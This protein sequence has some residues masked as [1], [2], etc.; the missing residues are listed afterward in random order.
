VDNDP[1]TIVAIR[2]LLEPLDCRVV[3]ARSG[4]EAVECAR[5]EDFAA[6]AMDIRM[7]G[8][9]GYAAASF[10]R[11]HSRG[12]STPILFFSGDEIDVAY[13]TRRYGNT[14][15]VD[16]LRK[17]FDPDV[18]RA[19]MRAWLDLYRKE[20]HVQ[21]LEQAVDVAQAQIRTKEDVLAMVAH[22]LRNPLAAI[23]V[24][25]AGMRR[26]LAANTEFSKLRESLLCHFDLTE[27]TV[28][29]M[30][31]IV[32]DLLDSVRIESTGLPLDIT[33]HGIAA[34][35]TQAVELLSPVAEQKAVALSMGTSELS[36]PV[37]CDRDRILQV[38]SNLLGNA[39]KFTPPRGRVQIE[40]LCTANEVEVSVRD[41][42]PGMTPDE[43]ERVFDKYWQRDRQAGQKGI[44]LGLSIAREIILARGGRI[45]VEGQLGK[46]S[47]FCFSL[48]RV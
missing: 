46:G 45:W 2:A 19:K 7:P 43:M 37:Q 21:E 40:T 14:G 24:S 9:D 27:R 15:Q 17:P 25:V 31:R 4:A 33:T 42:G 10:I 36:C 3:F 5:N 39:I 32:D 47:R 6:I 22:D 8:L 48:P 29:R 38:L 11:Q 1:G 28:E 12:S 26:Q 16:S 44:G 23:K 35:V 13:L 18:F 41:T 30:S 20:R 34:I